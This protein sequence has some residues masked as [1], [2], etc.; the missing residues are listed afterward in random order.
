M[1]GASILKDGTFKTGEFDEVSKSTFKI[2]RGA[3]SGMV[4]TTELNEVDFIANFSIKKDGS[5]LSKEFI[6]L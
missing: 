3:T 2:K 4:E 1:I 6:E 5:I